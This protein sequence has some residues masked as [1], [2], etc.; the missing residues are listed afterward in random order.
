LPLIGQALAQGCGVDAPG[1]L[2]SWLC[3]QI[4]VYAWPLPGKRY[5]IG[6]LPS[7]EAVNELFTLKA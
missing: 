5:D 3:K 4:E 2:M 6:D 7:Y 1:N